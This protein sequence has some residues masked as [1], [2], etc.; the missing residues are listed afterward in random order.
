[1]RRM[2]ALLSEIL[3]DVDGVLFDMDGVLLDTE[4]IYTEA[5]RRVLGPLADKFDW[6][7]KE[8][9]MGRAP[10]EAARIL[11]E[12]V[13]APFTPAEYNLLKK[14]I[15]LELFRNSPAKPGAEALVCELKTRGM[16]LAVATSSDRTYFDIKTMSHPWFSSFDAVVCGS[17]AEVARHKPAPDIFLVAARKLGLA[18]SR[19]LVFEDSVA[20]VEAARRAKVKRVVA[21]PDPQLDK[22]LL[23]GAHFTLAS[24]ELLLE[25]D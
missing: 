18:P 14:P 24:F 10:L 1:V 3:E 19:T 23:Q 8:R 25:P 13:G 4:A 6:R 15:L 12:A 7:I 21:L 20:G 17:D 16:P 11:I 5:T 2:G 9:M 22:N